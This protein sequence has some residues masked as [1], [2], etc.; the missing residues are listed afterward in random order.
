MSETINHS[1]SVRK[2]AAIMFTDIVSFSKQMGKDEHATLT[3]LD[4]HNNI[5]SQIIEK[6]KG[7]IIKSIGDA[8]FVEFDSSVS[9]VACAIETQTTLKE[10]NE[11]HPE[12]HPIVIRI[13]VHVGDVVKKNNDLF[14][15]GVNIA[16]RI[17]PKAE[18]GGICISEDVARQVRGKINLPMVKVGVGDLKNIDIPIILYQVALPWLKIKPAPAHPFKHFISDNKKILVAMSAVL[19]VGLLGWFGYSFFSQRISVPAGERSLVVLPFINAGEATNDFLVDGITDGIHK[20]LSK[21]KGALIISQSSTQKYKGNAVPMENIAGEM[22][23]RFVLSGNVQLTATDIHLIVS[24]YDGKV[25]TTLWEE[26]YDKPRSEITSAGEQVE[27]KIFELFEANMNVHQLHTTTISSEAYEDYLRGLYQSNKP[28]SSDNALAIEYYTKAVNKQPDFLTA[29]LALAEAKVRHYEYGWDNRR[30]ILN[31]AETML[32]NVLK[33]ERT[34]AQALAIYGS[35]EQLRGNQTKAMEYYQQSLNAD[36]SNLMALTRIGITYFQNLGEPAKAVTHFKRAHEISP[37][38]WMTNSNLGIGYAALKNFSEAK[39][40]FWKAAELQPDNENPWMNLGIVY[41]RLGARDSS[42]YCYQRAVEL[43]PANMRTYENFLPFTLAIQQYSLT[44]SLAIN[45]MKYLPSNQELFYFLGLAREHSGKNSDA[46]NTFKQGLRMTQF[47]LQK[48][49]LVADYHMYAS[50]FSAKM[51][52]RTDAILSAQKALELDSTNSY[53]VL[54][55][56]KV[57]A[58][59]GEKEDMLSWYEKARTLNSDFDAAYLATA[60]EFEQYRNDADLLLVA[61]M[62]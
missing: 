12:E 44:E 32:Q 27:A 24:L 4:I 11:A 41:E 35:I 33:H 28:G 61:R 38:G 21:L 36:P 60:I 7:R 26:R 46:Q 30:D 51:H 13:G 10:H 39:R 40:M 25:K 56:A 9:A 17:Q 59:L 52:L 31:E 37:N 3:L 8:F 43:E 2:L 45:A 57:A 5:V 15:D 47:K 50:L 58:I 23:V 16:A 1:E 34:D 20:H 62:K 22:G 48:N 29:M 14:G 54:N 19:L 55:R 53:A 49:E 18:P 42:L 6:H